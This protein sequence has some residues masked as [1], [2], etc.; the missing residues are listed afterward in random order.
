MPEKTTVLATAVILHTAPVEHRIVHLESLLHCS[1]TDM[2]NTFAH[3]TE[4][5]SSDYTFRKRISATT[6]LLCP[7]LYG[8]FNTNSIDH[9]LR[10]AHRKR[11]SP[12]KNLGALMI[13]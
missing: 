13:Y 7:L 10:L 3:L 5:L 1:S 12:T 11:E 4:S 9:T 6:S 2:V 8:L